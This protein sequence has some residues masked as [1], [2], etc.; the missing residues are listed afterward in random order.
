MDEIKQSHDPV[1]IVGI[2]CQLPGDI[3]T[4]NQFWN[5]LTQ[6]K[7][8][9]RPLHS[10]RWKWP[11][12]VDVTDG[13]RGIDQGVFFDNIDCFDASFFK[14]SPKE[15]K[16][17]DPQQRM[18]LEVS[19]Q[20][21]EDAGLNPQQ[22]AGSKTG[23]YIG[24]SNTDYHTLL[25]QAHQETGG[26]LS[27]G[28][29]HYA[30][31]N[32]LSYFF[33]FIGPSV[34]ID[35][36]SSSSLVALCQA[37]DAIRNQQCEQALVGGINLICTPDNS[38]SYYQAGMLSPDAKC[39]SFDA[40]ANGYVRGEGGAVVFL[41]RLSKAISDGHYIYGV[42]RGSG[43]NHNG[44]TSSITVPSAFAQA[45][46]LR[47]IY[48]SVDFKLETLSY[49]ETHG[50]GTPVGDPLEI[51]GLTRAF[52]GLSNKKW[53]CALGSVKSN[54]GH[55][56]PASGI[57]GLLKVLMAFQHKQLPATLN[58]TH[59]NPN[60]NFTDTPFYV[61]DKSEAWIRQCH[62]G[63]EQPLRAGVSSFG[64][65]GVNAHV[66]LEEYVDK[67]PC[68]DPIKSN[69]LLT[70]IPLLRKFA[71]IPREVDRNDAPQL[72]VF[73]AK[74]K[75]ALNNTIEK[76]LSYFSSEECHH[77]I[78]DIAYTLQVGR[79]TL[80]ERFAVVAMNQAEVPGLLQAY[81][82]GDFIDCQYYVGSV[83]LAENS[84][85]PQ[86][87]T[88]ELALK[89]F[90]L[91][92]L[93]EWWVKGA[94]I[95]W[96][97]IHPSFRRRVPLPTYSFIKEKHWVT[98]QET[99]KLPLFT[100][101]CISDLQQNIL[102]IMATVL[103]IESDHIGQDVEMSEL[104]F[105]SL[106]FHE[107]AR[108]INEC[109]GLR[110]T[111]AVFFE[112]HTLAGLT[113]YLQEELKKSS[114]VETNMQAS[115]DETGVMTQPSS[116]KQAQDIAIIGMAAT[117]PKSENLNQF[118]N[119]LISGIDLVDEIPN[120][121]WGR[122]AFMSSEQPEIRLGG[123]I[124]NVEKFDPEFFHISPLEAEL[125][126]PQQRC[127]MQSIW[128]TIADA[129]IDVNT[130]SD[131]NTG[132]FVGVMGA[133]YSELI[134]ANKIAVNAYTPIGLA[135]SMLANRISF[136]L[137]MK[138]PSEAIDTAC[139]SSLVA[140]HRAVVALQ[141]GECDMAF[142]GGVNLILSPTQSKA[143]SHAGMLSKDARCKTFD[144]S[145]NGYVRAESVA[146][147]LL[148]PLSQAILDGDVIH[149][150]IKGSAVNHGGR[151][152]SLT[153]PNANAQADLLVDAYTQANID[154][155]H[156]G[157][158]ETHGTGTS[159]GDPVEI[160]G[161]KKAFSRLYS[162]WGHEQLPKSHCGLGSVKSNMGHAEAAAGIAGIIKVLLAMK[163]N[164]LPGTL[165]FNELN[166]FIDLSQS[167]FYI[168]D[169]NQDWSPLRNTDNQP[170]PRY[171]G[172]S[173]FGFGGVN[174]HVV[175]SDY[176]STSCVRAEY[177]HHFNLAR[178]WFAPEVR[179]CE[180]SEDERGETMTEAQFSYWQDA[181]D[182]DATPMKFDE[183]IVVLLEPEN[184]LMSGESFFLETAQ[185]IYMV[186]ESATLATRYYEYAIRLFAL[187]KG[188][189]ENKPKHNI[190][191]Q[192]VVPSQYERIVYS[193]LS[194]L[195]KSAHLENPAIIG[196]LIQIDSQ[197]KSNSLLTK[198]QRNVDV[199]EADIRYQQGVRQ[200]QRWFCLPPFEVNA[201]WKSK[202]VY[203]ITG[204]MGELG[205][206]FA[207]DIACKA[208]SSIIILTGRSLF[209]KQI[210]TRLKQLEQQGSVAEY[211][212][213]NVADERAVEVLI[214]DILIQHGALN[215]IIHAAGVLQD[216]YILHK[217]ESEFKTVFTPKVEGVIALDNASK[218]ISLDFFV[219]FS[220][221]VGC[222]GNS[223]QA[224]YATANAFMDAYISY[225]NQ[226]VLEGKRQG[227]SLTMNWP[228]WQQGGMQMN[229]ASVDYLSSKFGMV[230]INNEQ[231]L[232]AFYQSLRSSGEQFLVGIGDKQHLLLTRDSNIE[233]I[234]ADVLERLKQ[235]VSSAVKMPVDK[236]VGDTL[237]RE[238]GIDSIMVIHLN[239]QFELI[240]GDISKT[241]LYEY[242]TLNELS[243]YLITS[244]Q[245]E[246]LAWTGAAQFK[247]TSIPHTTQAVE[248]SL[249]KNKSND[250][251]A[252]IGLAGRY[253]DAEDVH[254]FWENLKEGKESI[255]HIPSDR[256][257]WEEYFVPHESYSS[258]QN[259]SYS[260]WGGFLSGFNEFDSL[261][262]HISPR[263]SLSIDPHERLFLQ[264][265]WEVMEDAGYTQKK[266]EK[267]HVGVF[268]GI[269]KTGFE[270]YGSEEGMKQGF[271]PR[272]SFSSV[273]NRVSYCFNFDG[274]SL[275]IDTM[276]SS[277]LT[278]MH[279]ACQHIANG[280]CNLALVGGVNLYLHPSNYVYLSQM[281]ML[282][283]DGKNCSFGAHASGFVPGE[284]VGAILLKRLVD[285]ERDGDNIYGVICSTVV[286]HGG[287]TSGYT[288][289]NPNAQRE[290]V[291]RAITEA[292][293]NA[294]EI[295]YIE[296]HG[297]GTILGDPIEIA[298][299]TQ[300]FHSFSDDK[301][302]CAIGSVKSNIGHLEAAAGIAGV[303]KVL[304][305][306]KHQQQVPSLNAEELNPNINFLKT[307][308]YVQRMLTDW[309]AKTYG[310]ERIAG[311][312]SFGAGGTNAHVVVKE[313]IQRK[314]AMDVEDKPI[315]IIWSSKY[316]DGLRAYARKLHLFLSTGMAQSYP[317]LSLENVAYSLSVGR[318][319]M[320]FRAAMIVKS[321]AELL[322]RLQLFIQNTQPV[323]SFIF[324]GEV[325]K[326]NAVSL[327]QHS[328]VD[329]GASWV[330]GS[331]V[332]WED[333]YRGSQAQ[334]ISLPTYVFQKKKIWFSGNNSPLSFQ[335]QQNT[336]ECD[337][338][339]LAEMSGK[340]LPKLSL[341]PLLDSTTSINLIVNKGKNMDDSQQK[342]TLRPLTN[343][344]SN[345]PSGEIISEPLIISRDYL[346][347]MKAQLNAQLAEL[348]FL[349]KSEI[350]HDEAFVNL[351]LDSI[352]GVEWVKK[353][354]QHFGVK[355]SATKLYDY[356]TIH[357]L[358]AFLC[359]LAAPASQIK[360][361]HVFIS[362]TQQ[363]VEPEE[364]LLASVIVAPKG[365]EPF[366]RDHGFPLPDG[367][368]SDFSENIRSRNLDLLVS[369]IA[370]KSGVSSEPTQ[371]NSQKIAIIGMSG[372]FPGA[373]NIREFWSNLENGIDSVVD[374]PKNRWSI[375]SHY[376]PDPKVKGKVY[377]NQLGAVAD[378]D[379]FDS[380]FFNLSP[381]EAECMDPQ[382]RLFLQEAWRAFEDAGYTPEKLAGSQCGTYV[383]IMQN[384]Y[385]QMLYEHHD[386]KGSAQTALGNSSAIFAARMAYI[387]NL[388]GPA[389]AI[390]T[391]CSSS[392]VAAHMAATA[393]KTH[394]IDMA[395]V[396]GATLY[397]GVGGYLRMCDAGMLSPSGKCFSFDARA[398]GFVPGEAVTAV[399]LKRLDDAIRDNDPIYGV[400]VGSGLN[401]DGK[402]NG[403]TAPS[404][405]SQVELQRNIYQRFNI[406]P[407]TISYIETHGT[408]TKLGDPIEME[409]LIEVYGQYAGQRQ[410]CA[411]GSV[412]S[413]VGHT[414]A[415][416]G[417][418]SL[419]KV[420]LSMKHRQLV[421][422]LNYEKLNEHIDFT[423]S[424]FYVNTE[425]KSWTMPQH[426]PRR[427]AINSF[428]FSGT[429]AHMVVEEYQRDDVVQHNRQLLVHELVMIPLSAKKPEQLLELALQ[430]QRFLMS[431]QTNLLDLAYT[432]QTGRQSMLHRVV[433][434]V[435]N[436]NELIEKLA[437]FGR[438]I[439]EIDKVFHGKVAKNKSTTHLLYLD[440]DLQQ[441]IRQWIIKRKLRQLA[442][443]WVEG[444]EID[445]SLFY[446]EHSGARISL[447]TY[448]F[449]REKYWFTPSTSHVRKI[450]T[451]Q[452]MASV[453]VAPEVRL[454][455]RSEGSE[456]MSEAQNLVFA[457]YQW[458]VKALDESKRLQI[459]PQT[460]VFLID[461]PEHIVSKIKHKLM[462]S[463]EVMY[464]S[465]LSDLGECALQ[466]FTDVFFKVKE[467]LKEKK[468][469]N[470]QFIIVVP[471]LPLSCIYASLVS[472]LK[473]AALEHT[474]FKGKLIQFALSEKQD[475]DFVLQR[476][477]QE[478]NAAK[479]DT[480]I[481]YG[482]E[483]VR[484]IRCLVES[485]PLIMAPT[486][487]IKKGGVYWLI[488]GLGGLGKIF[489]RHFSS[490]HT[491][492]LIL[493]GRSVVT[494]ENQ[495]F[496]D[497]L[498]RHGSQVEYLQVNVSDKHQVKQ[499][500]QKIKQRYK[501]LNG[502]VHAAGVIHDALIHKK[503]SSDIRAVWQAK[504][505]GII[506]IDEATQFEPL[507]FMVLFSS[508][509][510]VLG[511]I[512]QVDYSGANAFLDGFAEFRNQQVRT[513]I[514]AGKTLSINWPL[515]RDG[516][517]SVD[518]Q[519][520][521]WFERRAGIVA[522]TTSQGLTAFDDALMS[523]H[524]SL[525][526][527]AGE[528]EKIRSYLAITHSNLDGF[529][530]SQVPNEP[531]GGHNG[532]QRTEMVQESVRQLCSDL[533][534]IN[535]QELELDLD[536][537][538]YG[539]DSILMMSMLNKLEEK[540]HQPVEPSVI[541][542]YPTIRA[543][544]DYLIRENIAGVS[545]ERE[546]EHTTVSTSRDL[547]NKSRAVGSEQVKT[548][549]KIAI[550]GQACRFPQ[551]PTLEKFWD[552][553]V[554]GHD[555]ITEVSADRWDASLVYSADKSEP[556]K[557]YTN[558][559]GFLDDIAAFDAAFF[560]IDEEE[561][562]TIDPQ[563]RIILELAQ[564]LFDRAGF[565][566]ERV[567]GTNTSV[568]IGAKENN[569]IRNHYA[570][571]PAGQLKHTIVNSIGNMIAARVSDFYNL[572][573]VAK[574]ID[575]ACS[576]SLVAVHDACQSIIHGES[577]LAIAGGIFLLVD[578][579]AH[580]GFSKANVLSEEGKSYVFDERANGFVLGEGAGLVLLKDYEAAIRDGDPILG[581]IL[582]SAVNNDGKTMGLTVPNQEGQ[583]RVIQDALTRSNI[584][585]DA[586]SYLEAHGTGTLL[587]DPIEIR[588]ATQVYQAYTNEKQYCA[589]GSVKSNIGHTMT[590][591]GIASLIKV[592]LSMQHKK[593]PATLH[594]TQPHPRFKFGESPFYP[595][596]ELRDWLPRNGTRIAA[597]SSLGFGGTNCHMIIEE[598]GA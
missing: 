593:I 451:Q 423:N 383:G 293:M 527:V 137:N 374:V 421:P 107:L 560:G 86:R 302:Y 566:R 128:Q 297:T 176:P 386:Y 397:L 561:A 537:S 209:N 344:V 489:A 339:L 424:P 409:A 246:C 214:Q 85:V 589:L 53:R 68:S 303:T 523:G 253:P 123:F 433:F 47:E 206:I 406:D 236:I 466:I 9:I 278:A 306:F 240:F 19:W 596:T 575:T 284:G 448:P 419:Q 520:E 452:N 332:D 403:I 152:T 234:K 65:G 35:T 591:A 16:L 546:T 149:G 69:Q 146:A 254:Q 60:I 316:E 4:V 18:L 458:H 548:S 586:V 512:G 33:N 330:T 26:Y 463:V 411:I 283:A 233:T 78:G 525:L 503:E 217:T 282:S 446:T 173:S 188:I 190:R 168:V 40:S 239:K 545:R 220:S 20:C 88:M 572:T 291:A 337:R 464:S 90:N 308:F 521:L 118:W 375:E 510:S 415:A 235:L 329:I 66:V 201:P 542:D 273:A 565:T 112:T 384:D 400:I 3:N 286:N 94:K 449:S 226:L 402:S 536:F 365:A 434:L 28:S 574:T 335:V 355:I 352:I 456:T 547:A 102:Q 396:G 151:A 121:R 59:L 260:K 143:F 231:G 2:S 460:T 103:Q 210:G 299:L 243:D 496:I 114:I 275:A 455:E 486:S 205:Y 347:E 216:N 557:T 528:I 178:Y 530:S 488:G 457:H 517:M 41:K 269:T 154:P 361:N 559:G 526:V 554:H 563:H 48:S 202:G 156:L 203:L 305:Q 577:E 408:G 539:M 84:I 442:E 42:I 261:F 148:K 141:Q 56:E 77:P 357:D 189:I 354:S 139:S 298:G 270:A 474:R 482:H 197:Q 444:F 429:N 476:L 91:E 183:H 72:L 159:L 131:T 50:S 585:A 368:G 215:G 267:Y 379:A 101:T 487:T 345:E 447:P 461:F 312:S 160:N 499:T 83:A 87:A 515:W 96:S 250:A 497:E 237:F 277:S 390:D 362:D 256:W 340:Q 490:L 327:L 417:L 363:E 119:N 576:S 398:D 522:L 281:Q 372:R 179:L 22:L 326:P 99:C 31:A 76:F 24:I 182:L 595:N 459:S 44:H 325:N 570:Q 498:C 322:D 588:A 443:I 242:Q 304:L 380:L 469:D 27:T 204:G 248:H 518:K 289:P 562:A 241:V 366:A 230:T 373:N 324:L 225:R 285:A 93:A 258:N 341:R 223:G 175:L 133:D 509:A 300:A 290:L 342:I 292:G 392:L 89:K 34:A 436:L 138:G 491:V 391:A 244:Y 186:S 394:E 481:R 10:Q 12:N 1:A 73:S 317:Q 468:E 95:D 343:V 271:N 129:R 49:I 504:V 213:I 46:L 30:A 199:S 166:P 440:E 502:I 5:L 7:N 200:V 162:Q 67:R 381:V 187:I 333:L 108:R 307:P 227:K 252:I 224:D 315:L 579:F 21:I 592:L 553:L 544:A 540:Y 245:Q 55:L 92:Q 350:K 288:V 338:V 495:E 377:T 581:V 238:Y 257:N 370:T 251:I 174:A 263:E 348:L 276:C 349:D 124:P 6:E 360:Q 98:V 532:R 125:M 567:D 196:Q 43:V 221:F 470:A 153:A 212:A 80:S 480:H 268:V 135:H 401:Q 309:P 126:D 82:H 144:K 295:S 359:K 597:I 255:Q 54:I 506:H 465:T 266:L 484:E 367:R 180:R 194:G 321:L 445:W 543:L 219:V 232:I 157:Y 115:P 584:S 462:I 52:K 427:A 38:I 147:L 198:I 507:D 23:V 454:W 385:G 422:S 37:V 393:L 134:A 155:V 511:N 418:V 113:D 598:A 453:I 472:L 296:A 371:D 25:L 74:N 158:I 513:G 127:L 564:E 514:R 432:L 558:L 428:G 356:P 534:K 265:S 404:V 145:A 310:S 485:H 389:V 319:E 438:G 556:G 378:I 29:G 79:A 301:Q 262:F 165:H 274:P 111:P 568:F 435:S 39:N 437:E 172:V 529:L 117:M 177:S 494:V 97:R 493:S 524:D 478:I 120:E 555:L 247:A 61:V 573:G 222:L 311:I 109:Y 416:A 475:A 228:L 430:L 110:L 353:I 208:K 272:S 193:G 64:L 314:P 229:A 100:R 364:V 399:I 531:V 81:L 501:Q 425:L 167:P 405:A 535:P 106:A 479:R 473:V 410:Y 211:H 587:G 13:Y 45:A 578:S 161:L 132:L 249:L 431:S 571:I 382:S 500:V 519:T 414:S 191:L 70:H 279:V 195:L 71:K 441:G 336:T 313:Y 477:Q 122:E 185:C 104:G 395:L 471:E 63:E 140:V 516:G 412:K 130:F 323:S 569:Y 17:M 11:E 331:P 533:L 163:H 552:N 136:L 538:E 75:E 170:I 150:V 169:K 583:K 207:R 164:Q 142:A 259:K 32:R 549:R 51:E 467:W 57:F 407:L 36:A 439:Q 181:V 541:I 590:A 192:V 492:T 508:I 105:D 387:L 413:N 287:L 346:N 15:A 116:V 505:D 328:L 376:S 388:K 483:H 580:V 550:I 551:S 294:R 450:E 264:C 218:H 58:H 358:A 320:T 280:S 582:G 420:L 62:F 351:G 14:I 184:L 334:R 8:I 426:E 171:A 318:E 369:E 594:C